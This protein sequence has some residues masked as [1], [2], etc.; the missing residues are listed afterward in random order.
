MNLPQV[1][2]NKNGYEIRTEIFGMAKDIVIQDFNAK[3]AEYEMSTKKDPK[4]GEIV[5]KTTFPEFPGLAQ[6]LE[7]A[8]KI[9]SF[10]DKKNPRF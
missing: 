4:T 10:V 1:K 6:I 5:F 2:F 9:Y 7:T 8:E 3:L